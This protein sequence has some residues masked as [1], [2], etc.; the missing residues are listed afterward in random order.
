MVDGNRHAVQYLR[1]TVSMPRRHALELRTLR[2]LLAIADAGSI[3]V[4]ARVVHV[5]QPSL[6]RQLRHLE[7]NLGITLFSRR[8]SR[9]TLTA[10]GRQFLPVAR[11][12]IARADAARDAAAALAAGRMRT[13]TI[14]AP[15]ST[16]SDVLAPFFATLGPT[17]PLPA[18]WEEIP[19]NI[20]SALLRGAD[21]V[22]GTTPPPRE[23]G[24]RPLAELPVLAYVRTDHRWADRSS[25]SLAELAAEDLLVLNPD[26]HPRRALD[27]A[28]DRDGVV[29][30]AKQ[31][32]GSSR[33][34]QAL[35]AAGRGIAIVSDD[36]RFGLRPLEILGADGPVHINLY[37]AWE[38]EHH[39]AKTIA[40]LAQRL[41]AYCV[42]R[43]GPGAAPDFARR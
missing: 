6:S 8:N 43:Y 20:Y 40:E 38:G 32:F 19:H 2:Y 42:M 28:A 1:C 14:A 5:T 13:I 35:A 39:A 21:L 17:D 23:L 30:H 37:A 25:I 33:V 10:A 27:L 26:F 24:S 12:L 16:L 15:G 18:V 29:F 9:L 31:E 34:T 11:D 7:R 4:A 41:G 22:I 3:T 36:P